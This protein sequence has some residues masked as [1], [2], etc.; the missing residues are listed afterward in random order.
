MT[1][2]ADP[3]DLLRRQLAALREAGAVEAKL[4]PGG[5]LLHVVLGPVLPVPPA[6]RDATG[7]GAKAGAPIA[8]RE[9]PA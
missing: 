7:A 1:S 6:G 4:G 3:A 5:E 8:V 2:P 9:R